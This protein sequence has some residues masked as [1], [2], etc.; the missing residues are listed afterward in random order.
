M[1]KILGLSMLLLSFFLQLKAQNPLPNVVSGKV[2]RIGNFESRYIAPRIIDIWLPEGYSGSK[3]YPVL[4]MQDGQMLFDS[5]NSWNMQAWDIDDV[6]TELFEAKKI[7]EFIV[8]GIWNGGETRHSEYFPQ[9]TFAQL[10]QTERDTVV[11]Q[12]QRAGRTKETFT[13]QSDDYLKFLVKEL[14]PYIDKNYSVYKNRKNTFIAGSSMGGLISIYAICEYPEIFGGAACL[15][16]HWVGTFTL[17]NNPFPNALLSYLSKNLPNP[18]RHK[19]YFDCGDQTLDALYPDIQRKVDLLMT[20]RGYT[21]RNWV[22]KYF[23]GA[24]HSENS[25]H[26]R[27]DIPLAFLFGGFRAPTF[28]HTAQ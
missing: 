26:A 15:S 19:I 2:V 3:K 24:D 7:R 9:K 11:A 1:K 10:T 21:D 14:K 16:T 13:P 22:T 5:R 23:P 12:L 28:S 6:A 25:W 20:A 4:Y 18:T 8:V 27:L 17:E